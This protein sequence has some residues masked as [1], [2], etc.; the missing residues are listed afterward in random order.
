MTLFNHRSRPTPGTGPTIHQP[1]HAALMRTWIDA[2]DAISFDFF[3]TLFV[4]SLLDP[5]DVFGIIGKRFGIKDFPALRRAAQTEAFR[6]M[7]Q[8]GRKEI[9]FEGIYACFKRLPVPIEDLMQAEYEMELSLV[10]PN[11]ELIELF[12]ETVSSEKP[13]VLTSDMY[14]PGRF[15]AEALQR[16]NLPRVPI[17]VSADRNATKRDSGELFDIVAADLGLSPERILHV[18][19]N[20]ES[21]IR[22]AGTKGFATYHYQEIRRPPHLRTVTPEASLARGLLRKHCDEIPQNSFQELGF[23]YGG[24]AAV[25]FLDWISEQAKRDR[26]DHILFLARDGYIL[27]RLAQSRPEGY[28]PRFDYFLGSRVVFTLAAMNESNFTEFLPFL[29]SGAGGLSPYELLQRI[30]VQPPSDKVM[31]DLGLGADIIVQPDLIPRL[32]AFLYAYRWQIL[33]VCQRNRRALFTYLNRLDIRPGSRVALVDIGWNGT[34]QDAFERAIHDLIET[35]VFGYYFCLA[36]TPECR[37]RQ[38]AKKMTAMFS[39]LST[40]VELIEHIYENRVGV[41]LFFS[42]PHPSVVGLTITGDRRVV[43]TEDYTKDNADHLAEISNEIVAGM[44]MFASSYHNLRDQLQVPTSSVDLAMPLIEFVTD[45]NWHRHTLLG[46]VK[47]FDCWSQTK[48]RETSFH[49]Y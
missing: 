44:E 21:D 7:Q 15:F 14:L 35:N 12:L 23:L 24:P 38:Q 26:I 13:V 49:D 2:A 31:E 9:T 32:Q 47:N 43:M 27:E 22:K 40:S 16:H 10:H 19:D 30:G 25:G 39:P 17:F 8:A 41:E 20:P 4:R 45:K 11:A 1:A 29:L 42:A 46:A 5:E 36:N 28:L 37:K 6:R 48:N 33:K 18:G 3:D 34:T